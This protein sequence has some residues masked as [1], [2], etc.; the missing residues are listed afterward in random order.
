M[1][2]QIAWHYTTGDYLIE[3]V[4]SGEIRPATANVPANERPAAWFSLE[5]HWEP[6]AQKALRNPDGAV[7]RLGMQG[8]YERCGG[9]AR[10][11]VALETCPHDWRAFKRLGGARAGMLRHME[12]LGRAQGADPALWRVSFEP[13][14]QR[15][16]TAID[17]WDGQL[18]ERKAEARGGQ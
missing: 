18:W 4:K 1:A 14:P 13:V 16:W 17:V 3:I 12:K 2:E 11:G 6:T 9:L 15:L 5:P 8:T 10:I 7:V